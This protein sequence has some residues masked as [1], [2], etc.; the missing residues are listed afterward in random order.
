[1]AEVEW[2]LQIPTLPCAGCPQLCSPGPIHGLGHL[3]DGAPTALGS[4]GESQSQLK[5]RFT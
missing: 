5:T 2:S 1:M 4:A 3:R